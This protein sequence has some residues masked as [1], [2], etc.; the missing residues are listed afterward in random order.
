M[1][2]PQTDRELQDG[3]VESATGAVWFSDNRVERRATCY[4]FYLWDD[5][6]GPASIKIC[7]YFPLPGK[8]WFNGHEWAK[9]QAA[10]TGIG[11]S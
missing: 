7:A 5:D 1:R 3:E 9:R 11:F 8:I 10:K 4:Y 6:F 2:G